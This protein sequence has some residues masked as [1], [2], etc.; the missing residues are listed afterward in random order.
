MFLEGKSIFVR[1]I[2]L[3]C[4]GMHGR[5]K[6]PCGRPEQ[7]PP[8]SVQY[9]AH[10]LAHN[11]CACN[12][13][14]CKLGNFAHCGRVACSWCKPTRGLTMGC[15]L[16][17]SF[18]IMMMHGEVPAATCCKR[19]VH[20]RLLTVTCTLLACSSTAVCVNLLLVMDVLVNANEC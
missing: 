17:R 8:L 6:V 7:Q 2:T 14:L 13:S 19:C 3:K 15:C 18:H 10:V 20:C 4:V 11:V 9:A 12:A 16:S 1:A 5:M